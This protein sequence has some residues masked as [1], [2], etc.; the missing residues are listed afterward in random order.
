MCAFPPDRFQLHLPLIIKWFNTQHTHTHN[1]TILFSAGAPFITSSTLLCV[2]CISSGEYFKPFF[3]YFCFF[4]ISLL[5]LPLGSS[6]FLNHPCRPLIDIISYI[7]CFYGILL[8]YRDTILPPPLSPY[9]F[10]AH[11]FSL[12][13]MEVVIN[14][15]LPFFEIEL[16]V[17]PHFTDKQFISFTYHP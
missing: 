17:F 12:S 1:K 2:S 15:P 4:L 3:Y 13:S 10:C 14:V 5:D 7:D 9:S 6:S 8:C 16:P 11:R